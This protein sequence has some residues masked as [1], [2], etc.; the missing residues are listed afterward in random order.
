MEPSKKRE[1]AFGHHWSGL[2][3]ESSDPDVVILPS[4]E[5]V[6]SFDEERDLMDDLPLS[7]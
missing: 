4:N 3:D 2:V 7:A 1:G 6:L 5:S